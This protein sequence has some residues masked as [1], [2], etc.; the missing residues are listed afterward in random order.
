MPPEVR[1]TVS[2]SGSLALSPTRSRTTW[3]VAASRQRL[4]LQVGYLLG[5][6]QPLQHRGRLRLPGA[7]PN[8][9]ADRQLRDLAAE[10]ADQR[11]RPAVDPV[12][13]VDR[14]QQRSLVGGPPAECEQRFDDPELVVGLRREPGGEPERLEHREGD[15]E[16]LALQLVGASAG[17]QHLRAPGDP[18]GG[19]EQRGLADSRGALDDQHA[20]AA[21]PARPAARRRSP[22]LLS[23]SSIGDQHTGSGDY[24]RPDLA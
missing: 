3:L 23:R 4:R 24:A 6:E 15:P 16:R 14:D 12:Q 21:R 7:Q 20:P 1:A 13:V 8:E 10:P 18:G 11:P 5:G 17:D 9:R 19:V 2:S 22:E